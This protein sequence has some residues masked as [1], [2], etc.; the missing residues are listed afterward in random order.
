M[1]GYNTT[2][3]TVIG[4]PFITNFPLP[5]DNRMVVDNEAGRLSIPNPV[6]YEGLV[7]Y[8]KDINVLYVLS[9]KGDTPAANVWSVITTSAAGFI[10]STGS[11]AISGSLVVTGPTTI[12][13]PT[14]SVT[15]HLFLVR[16]TDSADNK[17]VI[18]LEGVTVLGAF[19]E[20]PTPV[21]GGMFFSASGD[22]Y[23]GS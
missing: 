7:V 1:S 12:V 2:I 11:A 8:Q 21:E 23:L 18:N 16:S 19:S 10:E 13:A 20:T 5:L 4:A 14:S 9:E 17:F 6:L 22:F 15:N 3:G